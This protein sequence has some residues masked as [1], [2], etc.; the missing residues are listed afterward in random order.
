MNLDELLLNNEQWEVHKG[1]EPCGVF[2][3]FLQ[4]QDYLI[5]VVECDD[6]YKRAMM[7]CNVMEMWFGIIYWCVD[8]LILIYE[9]K[10][11]GLRP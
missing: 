3:H 6:V 1:G 7:W 9:S 4:I 10:E 8:L 11:D 2:Y 5:V